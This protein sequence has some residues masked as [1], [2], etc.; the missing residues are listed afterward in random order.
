MI[1]GINVLNK[2]PLTGLPTWADVTLVALVILGIIVATISLIKDWPAIV[3]KCSILI[4]VV[5]L[6]AWLGLINTV[7]TGDYRYE[8]TID[9]SVSYND[10]VKNYEIIEQRGDIWVLEDNT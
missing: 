6:V 10:I 9:D 3:C 5:A 4:T 1:N 7:K 8:C 2:I